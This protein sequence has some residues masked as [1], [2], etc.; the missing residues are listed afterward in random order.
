MPG[1]PNSSVSRN[2][3]NLDRAVAAEPA[4]F[5]SRTCSTLYRPVV[6]VAQVRGRLVPVSAAVVAG[7]RVIAWLVAGCVL[8]RGPFRGRVSKVLLARGIGGVGG[9]RVA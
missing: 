1:Q 5:S 4:T 9:G 7:V 6:A 8:W 2:A 3:R